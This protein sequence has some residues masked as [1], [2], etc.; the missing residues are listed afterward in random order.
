MNRKLILFVLLLVLGA[1]A[2]WMW[3]RSAPTT[4]DTPLSDFAVADTN[5]VSRIFISDQHGRTIDLKRMKAGWTVNDI[6]MAK[7]FDV[8]LLLR[9]FKRVQVKSPV[10]KSSEATA[11]RMMGAVARKVEIYEGADVPSKIWIVGHSTKDHF[12]TFMLL[13]KPGVG[14]S[15]VPFI[16]DM[17][18]FNGILNTRFHTELDNWRST[19]LFAYRD[20]RN[21]ASMELETPL[22]PTTSYRI[23]QTPDGRVS[24]FN[25]QGQ[26]MP[27]DTV[28]VKGALLPLR[29]VNYEAIERKMAP[30]SRDSLLAATPNHILRLKLRNG[31]TRLTKFW[32]MPYGGEEP[33]F[34]QPKPLHDQLRM[35]ALVQDTLLVVMQ[36]PS[37]ERIL[38]PISGFRP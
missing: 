34:G 36:R 38:Q 23:D 6:Y 9:T 10:P 12:G 21:V 4:L 22:A 26:A 31:D 8:N 5:R 28:L 13:E 27:F 18:G 3:S 33:A 30:R 1:V 15:S 32:Y 7:Q 25:G 16:M 35:H 19:E 2:F 14:R 37:T 29:E 17:S 24:L 20:L 11:L